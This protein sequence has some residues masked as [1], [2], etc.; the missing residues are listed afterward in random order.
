MKHLTLLTL[1]LLTIN[2]SPAQIIINEVLADP[3]SDNVLGDANGDGIR[4]STEDEFIE[5]LNISDSTVNL[6]NWEI[7]DAVSVRHIFSEGTV[8]EAGKALVIFGGNAPSE[9]GGSKSIDAST[10]NLALN[11]AGDSLSLLNQDKVVINTFVYA[12]PLGNDVSITLAI[13]G[14][15]TSGLR[16]HNEIS[17]NNIIHSPGTKNDGSSF[18]IITSYKPQFE[19][20]ASEISCYSL[21]GILLF[22]GEKS[23]FDLQKIDPIYK[24]LI[25]K[26]INSTQT[27]IRE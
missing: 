19:D 10:G 2:L 4:N 15:T 17:S 25:V 5:L 24:C 11:N 22:Q 18:M 3:A 20:F 12:P 7:H 26:T 1:L 27:I 6:S 21:Q 8:I 14:D 9:I 13:D 23:E 16:D